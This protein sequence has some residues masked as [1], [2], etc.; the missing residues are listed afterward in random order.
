VTVLKW[1]V[2]YCVYSGL[3][4]PRTYLYSL[5]LISAAAFAAN[6]PKLPSVPTEP[7]AKKKELLFS[8]DFERAELRN[9]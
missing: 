4:R 7:I 8:N 1:V 9:A 5:C 3:M 2:H 6:A